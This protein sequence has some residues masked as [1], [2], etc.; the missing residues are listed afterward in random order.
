MS[1]ADKLRYIADWFSAHRGL[2]DE[3]QVILRRI[4]DRPEE[5]DKPEKVKCPDRITPSDAVDNECPLKG[6]KQGPLITA[7]HPRSKPEGKLFVIRIRVLLI[8]APH[9]PNTKHPKKERHQFADVKRGHRRG[10]RYPHFHGP[11]DEGHSD[12]IVKER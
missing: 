6:R 5:M 2:K 4:A 9:S 10:F 12:V 1:D 3:Y 8:V 7:P 11:Y